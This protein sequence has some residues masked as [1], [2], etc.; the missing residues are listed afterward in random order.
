MS[1]HDFYFFAD[2]MTFF[3]K[4]KVIKY[5][6]FILFF[7]F[8]QNFKPEKKEKKI[9]HDLYLNDFNHIVTF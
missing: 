6:L 4:E 5:S 9:H 1:Q 3:S 2:L 7:I 8:V